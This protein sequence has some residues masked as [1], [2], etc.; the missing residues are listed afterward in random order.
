MPNNIQ[1]FLAS[2]D[3]RPLLVSQDG[4]ASFKAQI[5]YLMGHEHA[6]EMMGDTAMSMS[7]DDDEFWA[8]EGWVSRFRPYVVA[9]GILQIPIQGTLLN[10]FPYQLGRWATGYDYLERAVMRGMED[11]EVL[12]IALVIDSGGGEVAGCFE[13]VDKL[14]EM[15]GQKMIRSFAA[16][17]AYSAAY[18]LASV[19]DTITVT[20]S[21]GTG[22]VG[23]VTA[24]FNYEKAM[25]RMGVEVT[26]IH[27]GKHKVDGNSYEALPKEVKARIQARVDKTY[28]V[29]T[30]TVARNRNMDEDAIRSTEALTYDAD[31]SIEVGFADRI[32]SLEAEM[33]AFTD[34]VAEAEDFQM[35]TQ[36]KTTPVASATSAIFDQATQ[37]AAVERATTD[38]HAAGVAAE[39]DRM[40]AILNSDEAKE[41]PAAAMAAA[42]SGLDS[43]K[44]IAMLSKL[45]VET[46]TPATPA[47]TAASAPTPFE[48]HMNADGQP[49]V[50]ATAPTTEGDEGD[51][52]KATSAESIVADFRAHTGIQ[53][54]TA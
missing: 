43:D 19:G 16:D 26:F 47:A 48:A 45:S 12:A 33:I 54:K 2:F 18:A 21:G 3:A 29:F 28:G 40:N 35:T 14:Y 38:G 32:G 34:E 30:S 25:D 6:D 5:E 36:P 11:P 22:S 1:P 23:V 46:K 4:A 7:Q 52:T 17:H 13:L 42:Q 10:R 27:A 44:A 41:R 49:N 15:R 31:D 50:G 39:Q 20:R 24:H 9:N 8:D 37:D 53:K 51:Q